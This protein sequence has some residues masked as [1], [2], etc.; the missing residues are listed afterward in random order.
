KQLAYRAQ[1]RPGFEADRWELMIVETDTG[2]AWQG[3]PLSV[4]PNFDSW[5]GDY[6]WSGKVIRFTAEQQA[7]TP[8]FE[9]TPSEIKPVV[10]GGKEGNPAGTF[11]APSISLDGNAFACTVAGMIT[12]PEVLVARVGMGE[13]GQG[14]HVFAGDVSHANGSV[15]AKLDLPKPESV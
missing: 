8:V 7:T 10:W 2:G 9:L 6:V 3:K 13:A 5:V 1:K 4:T 11:A 12:P 14:L 15:L